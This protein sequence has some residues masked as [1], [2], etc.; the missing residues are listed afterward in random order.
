[1]KTLAQ[2]L[3][4]AVLG[5]GVGLGWNQ[6]HSKGIPLTLEPPPGSS[7]PGPAYLEH[8]Y[9]ATKA[10]P[11]S[12]RISVDEAYRLFLA[13]PVYLIDSRSEAEFEAMHIPGARNINHLTFPADIARNYTWLTHDPTPDVKAEFP[14][15]VPIVVYCNNPYCDQGASTLTGLWDFQ[16][17]RGKPFRRAKLMTEGL[18]GWKKKGY[19]VLVPVLRPDGRPVRDKDGQ[20]RYE[21]R[22]GASI[23]KLSDTGI[24]WLP[25]GPLF[26]ILVLLPWIVFTVLVRLGRQATGGVAS[27]LNGVSFVLRLGLGAVFLIAAY[28]KLADPSGFSRMVLCYEMVPLP[29]VPY[30]T[31]GLPGIEVLAGVLLVVGFGTRPVALTLLVLLLIFVIAVYSLM[32]RNMNCV[33][34]CFPGKHPVSWTRIYEDAAF[35]FAALLV[36]WRGNRWL[37]LDRLSRRKTT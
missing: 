3:L 25:S 11:P 30:F 16:S 19:H 10:F 29:L 24:A 2:A 13:G 14:D 22:T 7:G 6:V 8:F 4:I 23:P 35:I 9:D 5:T 26:A 28:F 37:A 21:E 31:V 36:Y 34:G 20:I 27:G 33:C 18:D 32:V 17:D 15:G 12:Q 1:L